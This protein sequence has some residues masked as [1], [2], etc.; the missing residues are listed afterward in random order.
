MTQ[1][2]TAVAVV[3]IVL[4]GGAS[5]VDVALFP[6]QTMALTWGAAALLLCCCVPARGLYWGLGASVVACVLIAFWQVTGG[7]AWLHTFFSEHSNAQIFAGDRALLPFSSPSSLGCFFAMAAPMLVGGAAHVATAATWATLCVA[8]L[9]MAASKAAVLAAALAGMV[10]LWRWSRSFAILVAALGAGA[11]ILLADGA[12]FIT[13]RLDYWTAASRMIAE[14]PF[15]GVGIGGFGDHFYHYV[16]TSFQFSYHAHSD[17]LHLA[18]EFGVWAGIAYCGLVGTILWRGVRSRASRFPM[19][20]LSA[21]AACSL[22][23]FSLYAPS[24]V[25]LAALVAGRIWNGDCPLTGKE[26]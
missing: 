12:G 25:I 6:S 14:H 3:C 4:F 7:L 26:K 11:A 21:F 18:A 5:R 9:V 10:C 8:G 13:S 2:L 15:V 24:L 19:A 1:T 16:P 20:G 22:V 23:D 17:P